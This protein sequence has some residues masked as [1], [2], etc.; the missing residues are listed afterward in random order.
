MKEIEE[1]KKQ[2][3]EKMKEIEEEKKQME[4]KLRDLQGI[5]RRVPSLCHLV[6]EPNLA[7]QASNIAGGMDGLATRPQ[8]HGG[9][10]SPGEWSSKLR[11]T[12]QALQFSTPTHVAFMKPATSRR[13]FAPARKILRRGLKPE[14]YFDKVVHASGR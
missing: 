3:E 11:R 6:Q 2:M 13:L 10:S 4:E 9:G 14:K 1:E 8:S 7:P 5:I 12:D